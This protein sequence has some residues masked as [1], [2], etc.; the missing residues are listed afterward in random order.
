[1]MLRL[2]ENGPSHADIEAALG[3]LIEGFVKN[4]P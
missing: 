4:P 1:M 2:D 3:R